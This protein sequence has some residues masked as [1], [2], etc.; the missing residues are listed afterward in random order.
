ML[1]KT[2]TQL[3]GVWGVL[4]MLFIGCNSG[5]EQPASDDKA[6][7]DAPEVFQYASEMGGAW[8]LVSCVKG[9]ESV[10]SDCD[11]SAIWTFTEELAEPLGDGTEMFLLT[12][13]N[14]APN[15]DMGL[16][17][18]K[19]RDMRDGT[20][21]ISKAKVG[22]FGGVTM[23]GMFQVQELG[24]KRMELIVQDAIFVFER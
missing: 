22:G 17:E 5:Q 16:Y 9:K 11:K 3:L 15:C 6:A 19:W 4:A 7:T 13:T 14:T 24:A 1:M 10:L 23:S 8:R 21:F 2:M 18:A 20:A 12:V